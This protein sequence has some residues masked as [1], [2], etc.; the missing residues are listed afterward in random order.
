M[1]LDHSLIGATSGATAFV[2][3]QGAI[4]RF[5][6]AIGDPNPVYRR[7]DVAPPTFPT[8]FRVAVPGLADID[9]ARF[10]H[11]NEEYTYQRPIRAG[12]VLTCRRRIAELFVK[13]GR[14]GRMVFVI[15]IIEGH[16]P[17]GALV[18]AGKSTVIVHGEG[19]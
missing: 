15:S 6:D 2:V 17:D 7:G 19:E 1:P 13:E 4:A 16:D 3:E 9:P 18:F 10:I 11:G 5:A 12:D 8:T 14:L